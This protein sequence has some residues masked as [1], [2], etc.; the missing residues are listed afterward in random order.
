[1]IDKTI[2]HLQAN[3]ADNVERLKEFLRIPSI[4]TDPAAAG[5]VKRCAEWVKACFTGCGLE[6]EIIDTP[7]HPVVFADSGPASSDGPTVLI[8]GHY[9]VQ[10]TGEEHLWNS[11]AFD[12]TIRGGAIF[13]RGSADDKGQVFCHLLAAEAWMKEAG[14]LPV[15]VK[16]VIEGEEEVGSPNLPGF[17]HKHSDRLACDYVALSDTAK[18]SAEQ[19]AITYGTKGMIYKEIKVFGPGQDLHSGAFGGTVA[20]PGNALATIIASLRDARTGKVLIPGFYDDVRELNAQEK[21]NMA[22]LPWDDETY[23]GL[24]KASKLVGEEGYSTLER[25]W[26]RP[27]LDVNGMF[28][29][30]TG[31]GQATIVPAWVKAKVSMR[32]VPDQDPRKISAAF[33]EAVK[34]ASPDGVAVEVE[35]LNLCAAYVSEIDSPGMRAAASA[36]EA[37]FGKAPVYTREGGT[38]PI[39]PLFKEV[40]GADSLMM[41]YCVPECNLHG[42]NE[43]LAISDFHSGTKSSAWFLHHLAEAK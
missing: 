10:P 14:K 2:A 11:P 27:T 43:F 39:L 9:D 20:N 33:D 34:A 4:S 38:L 23:R 12:P 7:G 8:Y 30:F 28:G 32:I 41:G 5:D 36:I 17:M 25:R 19:P 24:V 13:A 18:L 6:A 16:Y 21:Q 3:E 29:G 35:T 40:L 22:C 42:P 15:R 26:A 31:E 37:G 1:M